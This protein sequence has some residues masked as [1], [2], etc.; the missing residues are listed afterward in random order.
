[1]KYSFCAWQR[2]C[3]AA[4]CCPIFSFFFFFYHSLVLP[5]RLFFYVRT[6]QPSF[7]FLSLQLHPWFFFF[8]LR[9]SL[10]ICPVFFLLLFF[11]HNK[12]NVLHFPF[13]LNF[14]FVC[15]VRSIILDTS[16]PLPAVCPSNQRRP[17]SFSTTSI[18]FQS[19]AIQLFAIRYYTLHVTSTPWHVPPPPKA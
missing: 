6:L 15:L 16:F 13:L 14:F 4:V 11:N 3:F 5:F 10:H 18:D 17:R 19:F 1:M 12:K 9:F 8:F 2:C 7:L